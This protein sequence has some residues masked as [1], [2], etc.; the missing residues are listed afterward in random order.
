MILLGRIEK[1]DL[2]LR[3]L[4]IIRKVSELVTRT[5]KT[6]RGVSTECQMTL[7]SVLLSVNPIASRE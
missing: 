7:V 3:S 4:E 6:K 5:R 1:A 2:K